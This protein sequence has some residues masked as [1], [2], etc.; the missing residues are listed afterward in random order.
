MEEDDG[1]PKGSRPKGH[2]Q[3]SVGGVRADDRE[4]ERGEKGKEE[5]C[6]ASLP[7]LLSLSLSVTGNRSGHW[8]L[9]TAALS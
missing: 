8:T 3:G 7:L 6:G 1:R 9:S 4:R 5:S 2:M